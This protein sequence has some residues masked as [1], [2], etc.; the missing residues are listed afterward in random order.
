MARTAGLK[1]IPLPRVRAILE[2][3]RQGTHD[4]YCPLSSIE[5][6]LGAPL[7]PLSE[8]FQA[9][10]AHGGR[11]V[12]LRLTPTAIRQ[13]SAIAGVPIQFLE[14]TPASI[15]LGLLRSMLRLAIE[16]RDR[17][18]LLRLKGRRAPR[19]RAVLPSSHVRFDDL[20]VLAELEATLGDA[21]RDFRVVN[22]NVNEDLLCVRGL[23]SNPL[24]LS[25][26]QR[27]DPAAAGIDIVSSE[28]GRALEL[29]HV[30]VRVVCSNGMTSVLR[31]GS[32]KTRHTS[33]DRAAFRART[34]LAID[35]ALEQGREMSA[36][37]A[38]FRSAFVKAP[39]S[40]VEAILQR[41]RLGS[42][43]GRFGRWVMTELDK[44]L[45][46]FGVT[47]FEIVQAFTAVA[48]GLQPIHRRRLED[49]MG[50]YVAAPAPAER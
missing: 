27:P 20:D 13:I 15:G 30:L 47:R 50:A 19:L 43:D 18:L 28:T 45:S 2:S 31:N 22:L 3:N 1:T 10:V 34:A 44:N 41:H 25:T 26:S 4:I 42:L 5:L 38:A 12:R 35:R 37:L 46:L 11:R 29:R 14:K 9:R 39:R 8:R 16:A 6:D 48:R 36:Q 49:A 7:A 32:E 17:A 21:G 40:E 33:M 24:D 23:F